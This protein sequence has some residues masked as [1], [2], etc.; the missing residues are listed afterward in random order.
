MDVPV[1]IWTIWK[2]RTMISPPLSLF[3]IAP[4]THHGASSAT[5]K[6]SVWSNPSYPSAQAPARKEAG[7]RWAAGTSELPRPLQAREGWW[8][9]SQPWIPSCGR[10]FTLESPNALWDARKSARKV[11]SGRLLARVFVAVPAELNLNHSLQGR[12]G[13]MGQRLSHSGPPANLQDHVQKWISR[14]GN[15]F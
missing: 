2:S 10:P 15:L 3:R 6:N 14:T 7:T 8:K 4:P 13:Y 12:Q 11:W 9:A 1:D 5:V